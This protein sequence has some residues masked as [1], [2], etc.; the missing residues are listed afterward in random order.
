MDHIIRSISY[1]PYHT[2]H[3]TSTLKLRE[4]HLS[5]RDKSTDLVMDIDKN[6]SAAEFKYKHGRGE[7]VTR[8]L[9]TVEDYE[10]EEE[11]Y[12]SGCDENSDSE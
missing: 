6:Q 3:I 5:K 12:D 7:N 9:E 4:R 1:G 8:H 11:E 2:V 10:S